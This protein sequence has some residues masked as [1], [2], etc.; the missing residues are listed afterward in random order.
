MT[1]GSKGKNRM[2]NKMTRPPVQKKKALGWVLGP[3]VGCFCNL[4]KSL[5]LSE[6]PCLLQRGG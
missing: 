6:P 3:K 5:L 4:R 2:E 1:A